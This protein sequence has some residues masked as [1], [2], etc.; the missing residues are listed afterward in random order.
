[1]CAFME[2]V[3]RETNIACLFLSNIAVVQKF[4]HQTYP[5][6]SSA[7]EISEDSDPFL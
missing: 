5:S 4:R 1:M 7:F 2:K 6:L 3:P